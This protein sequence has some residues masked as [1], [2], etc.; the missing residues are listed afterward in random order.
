MTDLHDAVTIA[1]VRNFELGIAT[2]AFNTYFYKTPHALADLLGPGYFDSAIDAQ[3][4]RHDRI[5]VLASCDCLVPE[6]ATLVVKDVVNTGHA[7][8]VLVTLL[9]CNKNK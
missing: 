9:F 8:H 5:E 4:R 6:Y 1:D 7:K 3:P 2:K